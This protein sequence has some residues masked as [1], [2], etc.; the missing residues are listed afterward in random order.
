[1]SIH[2]WIKDWQVWLLDSSFVPVQ[3]I[4]SELKRFRLHWAILDEC[5][6]TCAIPIASQ[7]YSLID[8]TQ[9]QFLYVQRGDRAQVFAIEN[10]K[11]A[12]NPRSRRW[13]LCEL[14]GRGGNSYFLD[15]RILQPAPSSAD[16]MDSATGYIDNVIKE[17]VRHQC[18]PGTAYQDPNGQDRGIA[19][20]TVAA[21][22]GEH[23][24]SATYERGGILWD[25]L[26]AICQDQGIDIT[27]TPTWN[28]TGNAITFTFDTW[29]PRRGSD[30]TPGNPNPVILSDV[31]QVMGRSEWY[32]DKLKAR[33]HGYGADGHSV[34][35]NPGASGTFRREI[36][37]EVTGESAVRD[38][39]TG[40]R[41]E[42]GHTWSFVESEAYQL[43]RDFWIG[44][45]IAHYDS[46]L[47]TRVVCEELTGFNISIQDDAV[48]SEEIELIFGAEKP[49]STRGGGGGRM[50]PAIPRPDWGLMDDAGVI[51]SPTLENKIQI[52]GS[53]GITT[54]AGTHVLTV[55]FNPSILDHGELSG[56]EDDDHT[57][58]L[59]NGRHEALTTNL[60]FGKAAVSND[61]PGVHFEGMFWVD[62]DEPSPDMAG[63][64]DLWFM[65]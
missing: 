15:C 6:F 26:K 16:E 47:R 51:V 23:P 61:E 3:R 25:A 57:Q 49:T 37:T 65:V 59:T 28:G 60:H 4:E 22:K 42:E 35:A 52:K 48:G 62:T 8:V 14:A 1:M 5:S 43:G 40:Y 38:I 12:W 56:L 44:D 18:Q 19:G 17:F 55:A 21:N 10:V 54:T 27:W 11:L 29:Y 9:D 33:T 24:T 50:R 46:R 34:Y 20:L 45:K 7:F 2:T 64:A 41:A 58:Y 32:I 53:S 30:R 36:I 13:D 63:L 39:L 31:Y